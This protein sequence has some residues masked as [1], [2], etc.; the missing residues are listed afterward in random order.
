KYHL[1]DD[2]YLASVLG[3]GYLSD[4]MRRISANTSSMANGNTKNKLCGSG[5]WLRITRIS[6]PS[7]ATM[8]KPPNKDPLLPM[9]IILY[10]LEA[11][12]KSGYPL[13]LWSK[14]SI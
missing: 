9:A 10:E 1:N 8:R 13:I 7:T 11:V 2:R 5:N 12:G 4:F 14:W 6:R 3:G